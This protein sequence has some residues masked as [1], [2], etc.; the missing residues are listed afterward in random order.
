MSG[1]NQRSENSENHGADDD[2]VEFE[3]RAV[4]NEVQL[5]RC[6]IAQNEQH[7]HDE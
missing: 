1:V 6:R 4:E 7:Q 3:T 2:L 5:H